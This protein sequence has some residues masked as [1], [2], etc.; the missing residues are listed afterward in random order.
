M[1][2]YFKLRYP[3][4]DGLIS[5]INIHGCLLYKV[6]ISRCYRWIPV[7]PVDYRLLGVFWKENMY[8]DTKVPF[9]LRTGAL[10]AQRTTNAISHI[11]RQI[12]YDSINYIDDFGSAEDPIS[13]DNA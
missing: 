6:D 13:A 5:L 3:T 9:G 11:Y 1:G 7:D 2:E 10:A 4:I 12:G 8:F